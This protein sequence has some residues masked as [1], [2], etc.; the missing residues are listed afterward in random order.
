MLT[1]AWPRPSAVDDDR[2]LETDIMR[3][4]AILGFCLMAVFALIQS[5]PTSQQTGGVGLQTQARLEQ[6]LSQVQEQ[7]RSLLGKVASLQAQVDELEQTNSGLLAEQQ[8]LTEQLDLAEQQLLEQL[9]SAQQLVQ[10]LENDQQA[11]AS[12]QSEVRGLQRQAYR[13]QLRLESVERSLAEQESAALAQTPVS[14][15]RPVAVPKT[16][17]P[18]APASVE[19]PS[20]T[21]RYASTAAIERLIAG[22][23]TVLYGVSG[24]RAWRSTPEGNFVPTVKPNR[25]YEL[26]ETPGQRLV[27]RFRRS[28]GLLSAAGV[29]WWVTLD[30]DIVAQI[31]KHLETQRSGQLVI[32][33]NGQV[34]HQPAAAVALTE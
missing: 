24:Q 19:P 22:R 8:Q 32:Q 7:V 16:P 9:V 30:A 15:P 17:I 26:T 29:Q 6:Q 33:A 34:L 27:Q 4:M 14:P 28:S 31:S 13:E 1:S 5:I 23:R 11:L 12:L 25:P 20:L 10:K 2:A 21:M 18:P 3:F